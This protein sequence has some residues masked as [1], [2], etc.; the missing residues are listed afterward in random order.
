MEEEKDMQE[1]RDESRPQPDAHLPEENG[2]QTPPEIPD[3]IKTEKEWAD[4]L[5]MDYDPAEAMA[6]AA[7]SNSAPKPDEFQP[8]R[9]RITMMP[10]DEQLPPRIQQPPMPPTFMVWAIISTI[11][12]CLPAG[13]AAIFFAAQV[14]SKYY[15]R[16]YEGAKRASERA[17]IWIIASIVLGI[18]GNVL[19][20]PFSMLTSGI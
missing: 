7:D 15:A 3:E 4:K 5:H 8:Q 16:D 6:N 2:M 12:C 1:R 18:V 20:I 19:S 17:E 9:S 13:V 11:C 14:S 10:P